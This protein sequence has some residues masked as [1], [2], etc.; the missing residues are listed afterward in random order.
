MCGIAG[1]LKSG[2]VNPPGQ[3]ILDMVTSLAHRGPDETGVYLDKYVCLGHSRLSIIGVDGGTQPL[4]NEDG[5]LWI[6]YNGEVF[7]YIELKEELVSRGHCF[8]TM[9]DTEVLLHLYEELGPGCLERING[10]FALAIWDNVK[11]ELFLARDRVGIRP[12]YYCSSPGRFLFASEIKAL[13]LDL[14]VRRE[15]DLESLGQAFTFWTTLTPGTIFKGVYELPPGYYMILKDGR[16]EQFCYWRIPHYGGSDQWTGTIEEAGEELALLL[17]DAVRVRL[18]A[19]VPVGAYLSG[20]LD[21]SILTTIVAGNFDN[22]LRTFSMGFQE[23]PFDESRFQ[24]EMVK[25]LGTYH[26]YLQVTNADIRANFPDVVRHAEIPLLR[27]APVPLALL[28]G[29]VRSSGFKVVLTGEGAD[30]IFGGYNIFKEAKIRRF[31][32][33]AP[34]S[35]SRPLLLERLYPYIFSDPARLRHF[36]RNFF[37][38]RAEDLHDPFFSHRIRWENGR[39]NFSFL[40]DEARAHMVGYDPIAEMESHLPADFGDRDFLSKAQFLE[41]HLFLAG[42]LLSSQGDRV[43]MANSVELRHPYLDYRVVEFSFRLPPH[44]KIRGLTEKYILKRAFGRMIPETIRTRPKQPYRAPIREVFFSDGPDDYVGELLSEDYT[45]R[46][47]YFNPTRVRFLAAKFRETVQTQA[48]EWQNM[49]LVGILSTHLLHEQFVN[50]Y[51]H[52]KGEALLPDRV[53]H[54][55]GFGQ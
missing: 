36:L 44:W 49:A 52:P 21:S 5:S 47:G 39:K 37:V 43:A 42:Y 45:R 10:Q 19:D 53:I 14:E 28:S 4:C 34:A 35:E 2:G 24:K 33:K 3:L 26:S 22:R 54:G 12:L 25:T 51:P 23:V 32:G 38:V 11:K 16:M 46:A 18:R 55:P 9:T 27:T 15:I 50:S 48:N 31:W 29:L 13:F 17:T 20:G 41:M 40:S 1:I 30:E 8:S 7:N 6:V